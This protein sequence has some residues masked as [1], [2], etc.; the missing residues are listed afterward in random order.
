MIFAATVPMTGAMA[1]S[2]KPAAVEISLADFCGDSASLSI[3]VAGLRASDPK[4]AAATKTRE[5]WQ[6]L[7]D[8]YLASPR[9]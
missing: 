3:P 6:A 9:P 1:T 2:P 4:L 7:L 8:R 5:Q